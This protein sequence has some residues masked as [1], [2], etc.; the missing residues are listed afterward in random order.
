MAPILEK[1]GNLYY[2]MK[3]LGGEMHFE[4]MYMCKRYHSTNKI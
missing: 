2:L 3:Y 4:L 1:T